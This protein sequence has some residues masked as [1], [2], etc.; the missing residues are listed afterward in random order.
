MNRMPHIAITLLLLCGI[1]CFFSCGK[2]TSGSENPDTYAL[3]DT[4]VVGTLYSPTSFFLVKGD[5]MGYDYDLAKQFARDKKI[6]V[7]F[8]VMRS[9]SALEAM[10]DSGKIDLIAYN[11][12]VTAEY[13]ERVAHCGLENITHQVLI[14]PIKKGEPLI[15]DVTELVGKE[16]YVERNSKYESRLRNLNNEVGGGI[17]IHSI[18]RDT[19]MSE[20]LIEMVAEGEIPLTIVDSDIAKLDH[21]YYSN[22]DINLEVSF[23]QRSSWAVRKSEQWLADSINAWAQ[24]PRIV[25]TGRSLFH[26]YFETNKAT[27]SAAIDIKLLKKGIVSRYDEFFKTYAKNINWDWKL[28]A[29]QGYAES[30]FD[31]QATSWVGARGVMQLMPATARRY[32]LSEE[33]ITD[34]QRNIETAVK[35]IADLDKSLNKYVSDPEERK[36]FIIAAYNSGIAHIYDAIALATKYG[37][38]PQL[39]E[40]NVSDA[41]LMKGYPEY[42]NDEVCKYGYFRGKQT[43]SYV[44]EV[45][46][47]YHLY[48]KY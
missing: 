27:R 5:T 22:I 16:I 31:P 33:N 23:A 30:K 39:W 40:N 3:P 25:N 9:L 24:D 6:A 47:M 43:V 42:Y 48:K 10:L 12:P 4:L 38:N 44:Q 32:G 45:F 7:Q 21:T 28:L 15:S 1:F 19:I 36:K 8:E 29:A 46:K 26:H 37:K 17:I 11:T 20:D 2:K 18:S 35:V 41:L 13:N 14:Q 34:P